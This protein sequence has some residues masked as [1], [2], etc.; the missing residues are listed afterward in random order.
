MYLWF[1]HLTHPN[2]S[3]LRPSSRSLSYF[4]QI[5]ISP[6]IEPHVSFPFLFWREAE[7]VHRTSPTPQAFSNWIS[8]LRKHYH[9]QASKSRHCPDSLSSSSP[10]LS[11]SQTCQF[12]L[13]SFKFISFSLS[14]LPFFQ[15]IISF[16]KLQQLWTSHVA[17][18]L[19]IYGFS[20]ANE[21]QEDPMIWSLTRV[22]DLSPPKLGHTSYA[23]VTGSFSE[24]FH[25]AML[26]YCQ[27][28]TQSAASICKCFLTHPHH[29]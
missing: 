4:F 25:S 21:A 9:Y 27:S 3:S 16:A 7:G 13:L 1:C 15:F 24:I 26:T 22:S 10:S 23:P 6:A 8:S 20:L 14:P 2:I 19:E 5:T 12:Y 17:P 29:L 28:Y 18:L 11:N